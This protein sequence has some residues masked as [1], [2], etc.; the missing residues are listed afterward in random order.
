[1]YQETM[2]VHGC[3][4]RGC[5]LRRLPL[6]KTAW[7]TRTKLTVL[8]APYP[9]ATADTA[10]AH[11]P[12]PVATFCGRRC[13][14]RD[15]YGRLKGVRSNSPSLASLRRNSM[16][17]TSGWAGHSVSLPGFFAGAVAGEVGFS[18]S[19]GEW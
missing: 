15:Q 13:L 6:L 17:S 11:G 2:C 8:S 18:V 1:V 9:Q 12:F 19:C 7:A 14:R 5:A 4:S 10:V 16:V 3:V